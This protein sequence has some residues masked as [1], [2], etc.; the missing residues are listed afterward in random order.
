M[1]RLEILS[2]RQQGR[3][4]V[5]RRFPFRIGRS[6]QSHLVLADPGV[7]DEHCV[8]EYRPPD[9]FMIDSHAEA[10]TRVDG[11]PVEGS[12]RLRAVAEISLGAVRLRLALAD[13]VPRRLVLR[14]SLLWLILAGVLAGEI[15]LIRW[16][17]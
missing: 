16:L 17:P 14:E 13:P 10:A 15:W 8:L 5:A 6:S 3:V 4:V 9:G 12:R 7:W 2:G 1:V 11:E